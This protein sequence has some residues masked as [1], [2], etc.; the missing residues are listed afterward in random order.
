MFSKGQAGEIK[1]LKSN[2]LRLVM[3]NRG[4]NRTSVPEGIRVGRA[5]ET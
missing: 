5:A 4:R 2:P 1:S 3:G